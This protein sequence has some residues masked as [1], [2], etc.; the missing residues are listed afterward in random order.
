MRQIYN[1][2]GV[3]PPPLNEKKLAMELERRKTRRQTALL[4]LAGVTSVWCLIAVA[5][6]LYSVNVY[7]AAVCMSYVIATVYGAGIIAAVYIN[8]R[9]DFLCLSR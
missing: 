8:N 6:I 4:A 3:Q 2:D 5:F 1:F 9:R 7:M